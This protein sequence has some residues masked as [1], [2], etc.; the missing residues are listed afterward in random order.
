[1]AINKVTPRAL[2][3]ST[4]YKLVPSTAFIDALNVVVNEDESSQGDDGGD[5]GVIKNLRGNTALRFHTKKDV[6]ANGDYKVI[7]SVTDE[8]MKLVY[9]FVYHEDINEQG[10]WVYDPY[11]NLSLP[12]SYAKKYF[13]SSGIPVGTFDDV[14]P[15]QK[16]T[17]KCVARGSF[18]DFKQHSF[19]TGD[20]VYSNSLNVPREAAAPL[21]GGISSIGL[22]VTES[23]K[24]IYEK[25][26]HLYFTDNINEPKK[27][28]VTPSMF[29]FYL[30]FSSAVGQQ[31]PSS[32]IRQRLDINNDGVIDSFETGL[33]ASTLIGQ[34]I[35]TTPQPLLVNY[36][37]QTYLVE[38]LNDWDVDNDGSIGV[39]DVQNFLMMR[40]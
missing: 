8:K 36:E 2:D 32:E 33:M 21:R 11:G 14:D 39:F 18:F 28:N 24:N 34:V 15:Y 5:S 31:E 30:A 37:G 25:D 9:F 1:M 13:E 26:F 3:K 27:L 6:I 7:G 29:S 16:N 40:S 38:D 17:L 10:V 22:Q 4:D 20:V 23:E 19:I 12:V 35:T